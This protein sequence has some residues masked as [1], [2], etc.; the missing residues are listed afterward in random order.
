LWAGYEGD[1]KTLILG[2]GNTA[3][4]DDGV[5]CKVAQRLKKR[6]RGRSNIT[7]KE[8]AV[9]GLSLLDE[10]TGYERLII[11]DAIQTKGGKPGD[12]YKLSPG[13]FKTGR[14]AIVH[15]L[16]LVSTLELGRKLEMDMPREVIIFAIEAKDMATF[17][18]QCT[19]EVKKAIPKAVD[20]VL[21]EV[22]GEARLPS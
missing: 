8:T 21:R 4:T 2:I 16:G 11:V 6:L 5:G 1:M 22:G 17:S 18:E 15:D 10:L 12:I 19:P 14:M 9:S 7:V 3:L 13:D 20:M